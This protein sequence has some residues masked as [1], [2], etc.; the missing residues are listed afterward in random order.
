MVA[1]FTV[2]SKSLSAIDFI[3]NWL[4]F[5]DPEAPG[6]M[7]AFVCSTDFNEWTGEAHQI[8]VNNYYG[9]DSRAEAE[10]GT[11]TEDTLWR[12]DTNPL[13]RADSYKS[14]Y[15]DGQAEQKCSAYREISRNR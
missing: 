9:G 8:Y 6:K 3:T 4:T 1:S 13:T 11:W 12:Q 5:P 2:R 10:A 15:P 14:S 7:H